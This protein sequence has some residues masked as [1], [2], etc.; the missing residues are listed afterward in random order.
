MKGLIL[1]CLILFCFVSGI[2]Q[3]Y[4]QFENF[5]YFGGYH[6][7]IDG[8]TL[9][10]EKTDFLQELYLEPS[11]DLMIQN[12]ALVTYIADVHDVKLYSD[13]GPEGM[14]YILGRYSN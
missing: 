11:V 10:V 14:F 8:L 6:W 4:I 7:A 13:Q 3:R 1:T 9:Q 5:G 12:G 2:A